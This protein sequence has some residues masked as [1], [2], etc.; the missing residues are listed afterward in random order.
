MA[1]TIYDIAKATKKSHA[2]VSRALNNNPRIGIDTRRKILQVAREL[3][4]RPSHFGQALKSGKTRTLGVV[5]PD[6]SNPFYM[7]F[8]RGVEETCLEHKYQ[9]VTMEYALDAA[10]E[11]SCLEQMLERRCDG[12]IA[13]ISR[14]TPLKNLLEEFWKIH[15]PC[16]V[17]GLPGD[18]GESKI[19]GTQ[20]DIGK[21]IELAVEHLVKLGHRNIVMIA[22]WPKESS[23]GGRV[24]GLKVAFAKHGLRYDDESVFVHYTGNQLRDGYEATREL[25]TKQPDT[26]AIIGTNDI[27]ITGVMRYLSECGLSVPKDISL[28][29]TDNTWIGQ[30]WPVALTS[31]DCK[32]QIHAKSAA[33]LL[34]GRLNDKQ[35]KEPQRLTFTPSLV[36]RESTGKARDII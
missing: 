8:L 26:T 32:T 20:V 5:I 10:R 36:I 12:V 2:T 25:L 27:L 19:D 7:E 22:S 31:I 30:Y 3:G 35:W 15:L 33:N 4:Y 29:G 11:Y 23:G 17:A 14:F 28:V 24:E 9:L 34:F 16:V 1:V 21:G 18:V 13:F 6:F